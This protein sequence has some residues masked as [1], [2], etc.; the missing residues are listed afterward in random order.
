MCESPLLS[1]MRF[2]QGVAGSQRPRGTLVV[3]NTVASRPAPG[4]PKRLQAHIGPSRT[5]RL[6]SDSFLQPQFFPSLNKPKRIQSK[7]RVCQLHVMSRYYISILTEPK[8]SQL[9]STMSNPP[10]VCKTQ[11]CKRHVL[12]DSGI[13]LIQPTNKSRLNDWL[14]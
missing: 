11:L 7:S 8:P 14:Y 10:P 12:P 1:D 2:C 5:V 9:Q 4:T 13:N 3:T 6:Q